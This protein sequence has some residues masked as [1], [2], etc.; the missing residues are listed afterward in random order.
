M[1]ELVGIGPLRFSVREAGS[2]LWPALAE[3]SAVMVRVLEPLG[4]VVGV[5]V[6]HGDPLVRPEVSQCGCRTLGG[7]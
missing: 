3:E 1:P 2:C 6:V 4:G 7:T 5:P